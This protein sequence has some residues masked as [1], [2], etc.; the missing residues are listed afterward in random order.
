M[1]CRGNMIISILIV[2]QN[3]HGMWWWQ[4]PSGPNQSSQLTNKRPGPAVETHFTALQAVSYFFFPCFCQSDRAAARAEDFFWKYSWRFPSENWP[5]VNTAHSSPDILASTVLAPLA[6]N[7]FLR[8]R[9]AVP[10]MNQ[11]Y[12]FLTADAMQDDNDMFF[13]LFSP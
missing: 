7:C 9:Q 11:Y 6:N 10:V 13:P 5:G 12:S 8:N 3:I 1:R 2:T 4:L